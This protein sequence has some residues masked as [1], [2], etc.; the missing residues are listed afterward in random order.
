M[1]LEEEILRETRTV[2]VVGASPDAG[3]PSHRVFSYLRE[4]GYRVIPVNPLFSQIDGEASY[5][6]LAAIPERVDVVDVFRRS[7]D[8]LP[9]VEQAIGIGAK[10]VWMQEGVIN[11]SAA[12]RAREAGLQVV[13]DKCMRKEHLKMKGISE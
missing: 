4:Q 2:A 12:S 7:D 8:V 5:P 6:D 13:M 11:E 10:V 9:V 1:S 3:R